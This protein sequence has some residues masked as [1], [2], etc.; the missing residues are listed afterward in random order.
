MDACEGLDNDG[1][2]TQ[3]ARFQ[4]SML[5][6]AALAIIVV[7]NYHPRLPCRLQHSQPC[8]TAAYLLLFEACNA[9]QA[10]ASPSE[11]E[12]QQPLAHEDSMR[13]LKQGRLKTALRM[14]KSSS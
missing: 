14:L 2:A 11:G 10:H 13:A 9:G 5:P 6:G 3:V 1:T 12:A 4:G 8:V 7:P